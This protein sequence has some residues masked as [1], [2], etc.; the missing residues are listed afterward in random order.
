MRRAIERWPVLPAEG[1]HGLGLRSARTVSSRAP[2]LN[3]QGSHLPPVCARCCGISFGVLGTDPPD[4][5][6]AA[7]SWV[8]DVGSGPWTADRLQREASFADG[9]QARFVEYPVMTIAVVRA[10]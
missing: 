4:R 2:R 9:P 3:R 10:P 6:G 8:A 5:F 7:S 1:L